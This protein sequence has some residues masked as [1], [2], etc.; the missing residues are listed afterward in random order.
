MEDNEKTKEQLVNEL[1]EMRQRIYELEASGTRHIRVEEELKGTFLEKVI[2][3]TRDGIMITDEKGQITYVNTA[4]AELSGRSKEELIG[5]HTSVLAPKDEEYMEMFRGKLA[6]LFKCGSVSYETYFVSSGGDSIDVEWNTSMV[7]DEDG[8][9]IAAV[10]IMRDITERK[11]SEKDIKESRDFFEN[12]IKVSVDGIMIVDP[13]GNIVRTNKALQKMVGYTQEELIG[14]H[15][16]ELN[17]KEEKYRKISTGMVTRL[18]EKGSV[19]NAENMWMRK[20]G[21]LFPTEI[22]MALFKDGEGNYSGGVSIVRDITDRKRTEEELKGTKEFLE[23]LIETTIDGIM[24]NDL[25]GNITNVNSALEKMT[26]FNKEKLIGE[27]SSMLIKEDEEIKERFREKAAELFEKGYSSYESVLKKKDGKDIEVECNIT[28]AKDERGD[29]VAAISIFRDVTERK[30][31]EKDILESK[32]FLEK[33]FKTSTDA[34]IVTDSQGNITM[35]NDAMGM[36]VGYS[37]DELLGKH[38]SILTPPDKN[39][40]SEIVRDLKKLFQEGR[41]LG[42]ETIWQRKDGQQIFVESSKSLLKDKDGQI[43]GGVNFIRDVTEKKKIENML[44]QS[45]KLK[46]LGEL[47]GGVAHDFNNVLAAILG[48]VQLLSMNLE[49]PS[50][51]QDRRTVMSELRKGLEIIE[52]ASLDGAETVR[53]IQEFSRRRTDDKHFTRVD[54]NELINNALDFTKTRWKGETESKGIK[55]KIKKELSP[56]PPIAG[57][58]SELRE[59]F[60]NLINNAIDAMSQGG[61]IRIRTFKENNYIGIKV[62]DTDMGI[63]EEMRDRIFD[64]FYTTKGPQATGL[65]MSVSYE[66]ITRHEGTITVESQEG[67]GTTFTIKIPIK[68]VEVV[69][70]EKVQ[71]LPRKGRKGNIL[72]VEDEEDIRILL[73]EI[74]TSNGHVVSVASDGKKGVEIFRKGSFDLVL[75]DLGMP[76]MSGWEVASSVKKLAPEV[77]VAILTGWDIRLGKDELKQNGVDM[78]INKPFKVK[79]IMKLVQ[80]AIETKSKVKRG[81]A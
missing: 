14:K 79:Q 48:R 2:D 68:E 75:T 66:I 56:L 3:T 73:S 59:V 41:V 33:L 5:E 30:K 61:E 35:V 77:I 31:A 43:I 76:G 62:E 40:R 18:F 17:S 80:E 49:T 38:S 21:S 71:G 15:A 8:N 58:A 42:Y 7:E 53:R 6:K 39:L 44:L 37:K 51:K 64:P 63:S 9:Y 50:D 1:V 23:N 19:E 78:V 16:S 55:I 47:A 26:G 29:F 12:I 65:G 57:S 28:L 32:E 4:L 34:I 36:M 74:L 27:H 25:S 81:K 22:N 60:T 70:E 11:K 45:E 10:S 20:D 69:K 52:K 54:I 24:I 13:G 46:S 67:K 72:I